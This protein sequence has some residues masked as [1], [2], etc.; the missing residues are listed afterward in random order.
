MVISVLCVALS[1]AAGSIVLYNEFSRHWVLRSLAR[2]ILKIYCRAEYEGR[3]NVPLR[4]PLIVASNHVSWLDTVFLGSAVPRLIHYLVAREYYDPWYLKW[5]ML[6]FGAIP[7]MR[8]K[9]QR[10]PL[11]RALAALRGGRV[12]GVF[13]EARMSDTGDL[14]P[15]RGGVALLAEE[16]GVPVLP[17]AILGGNKVMGPTYRFPR[18]H[19]VRVR[20]G[21]LIDPTG[22]NR[23]EILA[24][25]DRAIRSLLGQPA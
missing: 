12:I 18:P 25:L 4:G 11:K 2:V 8:G 19:K 15:F 20:I 1:V 13:P 6:L 5:V 17:V 3:E 16:A 22:L 10:E 24:R 21:H 9:A 23:E 14:Q 7:L